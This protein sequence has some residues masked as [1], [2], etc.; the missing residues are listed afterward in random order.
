MVVLY[1]DSD[2]HTITDD[3]ENIV[4]VEEAKELFTTNRV[5]DCSQSLLRLQ[6]FGWDFDALDRFYDE[7]S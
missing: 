4:T 6:E 5:E 2:T 1:L 7:T 3:A